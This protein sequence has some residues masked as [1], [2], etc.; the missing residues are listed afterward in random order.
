[1]SALDDVKQARRVL[2]DTLAHWRDRTRPGDDV[3]TASDVTAA[4]AG[5]VFAMIA[6]EREH[7][8]E[9]RR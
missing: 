1:M 3:V 5:L 7:D 4:V 2:I 6:Q 8:R 9:H